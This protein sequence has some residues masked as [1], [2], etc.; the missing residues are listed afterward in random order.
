MSLLTK[1]LKSHTKPVA[2]VATLG[3]IL[4]VFVTNAPPAAAN[5]YLSVTFDA[6]VCQVSYGTWSTM[7]VEGALHN[8]TSDSA[9]FTV[10]GNAYSAEPGQSEKFE[11]SY[12]DDGEFDD[13]GATVDVFV[14]GTAEPLVSK[15]FQPSEC[16]PDLKIGY[17]T[18]VYTTTVAQPVITATNATR[19]SVVNVNSGIIEDEWF[20]ADEDVYKTQ[21]LTVTASQD[22]SSPGGLV[23]GDYRIVLEGPDSVLVKNFKVAAPSP[24]AKATGNQH[25]AKFQA[26]TSWTSRNT[27]YW[28]DGVKKGS[29]WSY[30]GT[31]HYLVKDG[32]A[33]TYTGNAPNVGNNKGKV[34]E[35]RIRVTF[36]WEILH[37][38]QWKVWKTTTKVVAFRHR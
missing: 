15:L 7:V 10:A 26:Q 35:N 33:G 32:V 12:L 3:L 9:H 20:F 23:Q 31:N 27:V 38:N 30:G 17:P 19:V 11:V 13:H 5:G 28:E 24:T 37:Y 18:V 1:W 4:G 34:S 22:P 25:Y 21:Q 29:A 6:P 16:S 8:G 14:E 2:F 36:V